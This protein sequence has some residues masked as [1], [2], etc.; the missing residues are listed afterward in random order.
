MKIPLASAEKNA[1]GLLQALLNDSLRVMRSQEYSP[2]ARMESQR[3]AR[4]IIEWN[5]IDGPLH[6]TRRDVVDVRDKIRV[7][8]TVDDPG[9]GESAFRR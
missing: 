4:M 8:M 3:V 5:T 1:V 9:P 6:Y 2:D 7:T